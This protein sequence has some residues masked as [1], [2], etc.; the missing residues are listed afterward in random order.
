MISNSKSVAGFRGITGKEVKFD[1]GEF[2]VT[3]IKKPKN[4]IELQEIIT[5]LLVESFNTKYMYIL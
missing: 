2:E 1:D 4:P 3:L 5:A